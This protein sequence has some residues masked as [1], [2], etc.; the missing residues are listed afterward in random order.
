MASDRRRV[1]KPR[2][3]SDKN[4]K[5][6]DRTARETKDEHDIF[7]AYVAA[8]LRKFRPTDHAIARNRIQN[9]IFGIEMS[10][11]VRK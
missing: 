1:K 2:K 7:G 11:W 4:I 6:R 8:S 3:R 5:P 9:L 10:A